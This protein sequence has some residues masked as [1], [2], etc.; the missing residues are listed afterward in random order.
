MGLSLSAVTGCIEVHSHPPVSAASRLC[1]QLMISCAL[2]H[3]C[4]H[5]QDWRLGYG[6]VLLQGPLEDLIHAHSHTR[7]GMGS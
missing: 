7:V 2:F 3:S 4:T 1:R 5:C 6:I